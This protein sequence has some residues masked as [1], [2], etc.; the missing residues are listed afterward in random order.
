MESPS[1]IEST[2]DSASSA[3]F[4]TLDLETDRDFP[5]GTVPLSF[6]DETFSGSELVSLLSSKA[7]AR[8]SSR[9]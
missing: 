1:T 4:G 9:A 2:K 7:G 3:C 6:F 8:P 5:L